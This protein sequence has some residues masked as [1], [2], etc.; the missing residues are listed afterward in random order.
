MEPKPGAS[1]KWDTLHRRRFLLQKRKTC[2][3]HSP[4][5]RKVPKRRANRQ[6]L[7]TT[8]Q[9]LEAPVQQTLASVANT[10]FSC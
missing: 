2:C 6:T 8:V 4:P 9:L 3:F 1:L 7:Q 5:E 10:V